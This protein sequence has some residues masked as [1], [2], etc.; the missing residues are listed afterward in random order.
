MMYLEFGGAAYS[1]PD[2]TIPI[3]EPPKISSST[4]FPSGVYLAPGV[5]TARGV[6]A[7]GDVLY[8]VQ[9]TYPGH[10][11]SGKLSRATGALYDDDIPE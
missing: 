2:L 3:T 11:V 7:W 9:F 6:N 1:D 8:T 5:H 10:I 4:N